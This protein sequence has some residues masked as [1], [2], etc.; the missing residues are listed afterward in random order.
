MTLVALWHGRNLQMPRR[1]HMG[2][3]VGLEH[4]AILRDVAGF[5]FKR[6]RSHFAPKV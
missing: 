4:V 6:I 1:Q 5:G 2:L 3:F